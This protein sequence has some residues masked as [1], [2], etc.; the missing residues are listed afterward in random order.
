MT[1]A[2][3]SYDLLM[4]ERPTVHRNQIAEA[5]N[6]LGKVIARARFAGEPTVLVNRGEEAAVIVSYED[7]ATLREL[8]D[9]VE[10]LEAGETA[11]SKQKARILGEALATAKL[12]AALDSS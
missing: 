10:E 8:R 6:V 11:D 7:Y 12:R 5:R 3:I 2:A 9:Y 4:S 1:I